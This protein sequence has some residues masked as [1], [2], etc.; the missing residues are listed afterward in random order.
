[1]KCHQCDNQFVVPVPAR[2]EASK[3]NADGASANYWLKPGQGSVP[4][5]KPNQP[6][7]PKLK[8][9][10]RSVT[11]A[12]KEQALL[13]HYSTG[14]SLEERIAER[15]RE[16]IEEGRV[17]NGIN[18]LIK[19]IL[20]LAA[21]AFFFWLLDTRDQ[22]T[23][24]MLTILTVPFHVFKA[25]YWLTPALALVGSYYVWIGVGSLRGNVDIDDQDILPE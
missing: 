2:P 23:W 8:P 6:K 21:A 5:P 14:S 22:D 25:E 13:D 15:R 4:E 11:K 9:D 24:S 12:D 20:W 1:M 16:R 10:C 19:G 18:F 3:R 17:S 7:K